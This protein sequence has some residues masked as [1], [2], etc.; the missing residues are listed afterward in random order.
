MAIAIHKEKHDAAH[1]VRFSAQE[2]GKE[3]GRAFLYV[4]KNDLHDEPFGLLEDVFVEDAH[5][6]RGIGTQLVHSVIEEAKARGCYKLIGQSRYGRDAAHAM[7]EN[8]GFKNHGYNFR[9]DF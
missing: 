6:G 8:I 3:I 5:R 2:E 4:L 1:A 9:M 7:Y